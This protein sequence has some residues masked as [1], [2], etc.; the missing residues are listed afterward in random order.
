MLLADR[1]IMRTGAHC[2]KHDQSDQSTSL[3]GALFIEDD[4]LKAGL[5][6]PPYQEQ[7]ALD[8]LALLEACSALLVR[9]GLLCTSACPAAV[10]SALPFP[11]T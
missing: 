2:Q 5:L 6:V 3:T 8:L 1:Q 10:L 11:G 7:R 9:S 4:N